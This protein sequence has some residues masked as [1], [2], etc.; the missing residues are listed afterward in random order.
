MGALSVLVGRLALTALQPARIARRGRGVGQA[1]RY[2]QC[3][4]EASTAGLRLI[5]ASHVMLASPAGKGH[6]LVLRLV[7]SELMQESARR[8]ARA[9]YPDDMQGKANQFVQFVN[10]E[11]TVAAGLRL[12][13]NVT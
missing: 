3:V 10:P 1:L 8:H 2:V 11:R 12:A 13:Q 5:S 7:L 9:A 4:K 6:Q